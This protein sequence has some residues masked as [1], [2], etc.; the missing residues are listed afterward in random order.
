M[1]RLSRNKQSQPALF[2]FRY[3]QG[4]TLEAAGGSRSAVPSQVQLVKK[5]AIWAHLLP[6]CLTS[7][8]EA[9]G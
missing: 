5:T 6:K 9:M 8:A 2:S 3:D 1:P 7:R 4:W